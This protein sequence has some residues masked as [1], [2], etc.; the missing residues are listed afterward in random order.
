MYVPDVSYFLDVCCKCVYMDIA[1]VDR[2]VAYTYVASV[3]PNVSFVFQT[4]VASVF[5]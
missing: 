3:V 5:I 1:K 2:D 4:Y